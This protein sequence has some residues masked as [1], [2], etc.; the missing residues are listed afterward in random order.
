MG[1]NL[2]FDILYTLLASITLK[3][4]QM[5]TLTGGCRFPIAK[6]IQRANCDEMR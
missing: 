2:L 4:Q 3:M 1:G 6:S 5:R